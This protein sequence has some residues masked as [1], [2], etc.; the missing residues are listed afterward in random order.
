[1]SQRELCVACG[2]DALQGTCLCPTHNQDVEDGLIILIGV[3]TVSGKRQ[4]TGEVMVMEF[5]TLINV[6][7]SA[8][9]DA[10]ASVAGSEIMCMDE[11]AMARV[12]RVADITHA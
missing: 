2:D 3:R 12:K 4:R 7:M 5:N 6:M 10:T 8:G 1:M 11:E 9:L